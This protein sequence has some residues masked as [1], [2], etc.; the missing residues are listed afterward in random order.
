M[1]INVIP[2]HR[3]HRED[4]AYERLVNKSMQHSLV[5]GWKTFQIMHRHNLTSSMRDLDSPSAHWQCCLF[6]SNTAS[7]RENGPTLQPLDRRQNE[8]H[9][10]HPTQYHTKGRHDVIPVP[11]DYAF[12]AGPMTGQFAMLAHTLVTSGRL[13]SSSRVACSSREDI[14]GSENDRFWQSTSKIGDGVE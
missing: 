12:A 3:L 13:A 10:E 5:Q 7:A 14:D 4:V 2:P 8:A 9:Q 11:L 1:R 6:S